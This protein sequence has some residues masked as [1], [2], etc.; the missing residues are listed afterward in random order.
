[1]SIILFSLFACGDDAKT[2][3]SAGSDDS[4]AQ[5]EVLPPTEPDA[6]TLSVTGDHTLSLVFD[7]PTCQIPDAA[8]NFN[9]FWRTSSGA[10]T[11]VL[12]VMIRG[13]YDGAGTYTLTENALTVTLQ[14]EAGGEGRYF[15]VN[16]DEGHDASVEL[17]TEADNIVWGSLTASQLSSINDGNIT[18]SPTE[19]PL[20]CD[21]NN[22]N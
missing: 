1:M 20:W 11:F 12:R 21:S 22:T 19:I 15:S 16:V 14:E 18:I 17:N 3:D 7:T 13:E 8:P 6:F 9:A 2:N 4:A 10:H 5:E